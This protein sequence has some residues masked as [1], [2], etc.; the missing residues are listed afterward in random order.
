MRRL[1]VV[2]LVLCAV[3]AIAQVPSG[4][5][6]YVFTNTPLWDT[7]GIYT[8]TALADAVVIMTQ[9]LSAKGQ[10]TGTLTETYFVSDADNFD[11]TGPIAG[12]L[13]V[14]SGVAGGSWKESGTMTGVNSGIDYTGTYTGTGTATIDPDTLTM[15]VTGSIKECVDKRC[16][17]TAESPTYTIPADMNGDWTLETDITAA[18]KKLTGTG[19]LTLS[20][21]REFDYTIIGSYNTKSGVAKLKLVGQGD[22]LG[23]SLSLTTHGT[24]MVLTTLKGKVLGQTPTVP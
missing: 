16:E 7:T 10:V 11:A 5:F 8:N 4:A 20:N 9:Q 12:R 6:S 1:L 17:T 15:L 22:A 13:S 24:N 18:A 19:T 21:D 14:K 2:L 3:P 23:T